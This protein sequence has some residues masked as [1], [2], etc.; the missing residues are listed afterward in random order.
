[1]SKGTAGEGIDDLGLPVDD[2]VIEDETTAEEVD[3]HDETTVT[4]ATQGS[5]ASTKKATDAKGTDAQDADESGATAGLDDVPFELA[6]DTPDP[7]E[8][9]ETGLVSEFV[10]VGNRQAAWLVSNRESTTAMRSP[11]FLVTAAVI[12]LGVLAAIISGIV[13]DVQKES[14]TPTMAMV[15]VGEQAQMYEQQLG[16]KITDAKDAPAAEKLVREGKVDAAFIQ[17]PSGQGQPTI[18]ALDKQ[19]DAL[20]EKLAPKTEATLLETPAVE[21]D[22]ATPLLWAM[23]ALSLSLIHI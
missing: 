14:G 7:D 18:I 21:N 2:D 23:V 9:P 4:G 1:M 16:V 12:I 19:P 6:E 10:D 22:V 8:L 5:A 17:D 13:A 3:S 11:Y 15:G 20:L